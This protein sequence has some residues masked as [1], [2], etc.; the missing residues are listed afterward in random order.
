MVRFRLLP[1]IGL[2]AAVGLILGCS[3]NQEFAAVD[4]KLDQLEVQL[5]ELRKQTATGGA[6]AELRGALDQ[7][8]ASLSSGQSGLASEIHAL[9]AQI[10]QLEAKLDD[11]NFR[12]T[13]LLQQLAAAHQELQSLRSG[14]LFA[15]PALVAPRPAP[16]SS[17]SPQA[18]YDTAQ[19][20][21]GRGNLDLAILAFRQYLESY[22]AAERAEDA[23][24]TLGDIYLRQGKYAK[25]L[26]QFDQL[27][28]RFPRGRH[29]AGA[30]LKK[31]YAYLEMGERAQ[32]IVQLQK[33]LCDH[34]GSPEAEQARRRLRELGIDATC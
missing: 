3:S 28:L 12:L 20:D 2:L 17:E 10:E 18:L 32:G 1:G 6:V 29:A 31:G 30:L 7:T 16:S 24:F 26:E 15:A 22:P 4:S 8:V 11:T 27:L 23:F 25:A 9:Q 33:V 5:L 21:L 13:Q 19:A 14:A 34:V